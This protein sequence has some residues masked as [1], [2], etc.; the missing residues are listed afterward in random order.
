[1]TAGSTRIDP[2]IPFADPRL[3][4]SLTGTG[5]VTATVRDLLTRT[6]TLADYDVAGTL[7][8]GASRL[9]DLRLDAADASTRRCATRR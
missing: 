9:R 1:M 6:V 3:E 7:T 4:A 8:L 5:T 2:S